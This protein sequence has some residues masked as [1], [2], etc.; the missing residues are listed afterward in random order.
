MRLLVLGGTEFVGRALVDEALARGWEVTVFHR[1]RHPAP[2]GVTVLHGDRT[3]PDGLLALNSGASGQ[4]AGPYW[5][6]VIDTWTGAPVAVRDAAAALA[7][8][9]EHYVYVSSRSVHS[10]PTAPG[11]DESAPLVD[12]DPDDKE[13]GDYARAKRGGELAATAA[14]GERAL[15][16][17]PGL[18]IGPGENIGRLPWWLNRAARGGPML[19]PGP[20]SLPLQYIDARDL[21]TWTLDALERGLGGA[22]NTVSE[23]GH[24]T[25]G[26]LLDAVVSATGNRAEPQWT[27]PDTLLLAG[28][29]PW[30]ELPIWVPPGELHDTLHGADVSK[31]HAEG[32]RCRPAAETVAATWQWLHALHG[33]APHRPDRPQVG[34]APEREAELLRQLPTT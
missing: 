12:G 5:D 32:L 29:E 33:Q 30:S 8:R 2:P 22:Y 19:A 17:R 21:A 16:P 4:A 3:A 34:L 28:V 26:A 14:F 10:H 15:L 1:G 25:M 7:S 24:T 11:A 9:A 20:R 31:A 27:A 23:R 18:V 13:D 6:A